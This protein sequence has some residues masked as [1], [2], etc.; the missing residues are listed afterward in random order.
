MNGDAGLTVRPY[1]PAVHPAAILALVA[2]T[3]LAVALD[4]WLINR[5][6]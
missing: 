6:R 4:H 2:V 1:T 5:P 3:I